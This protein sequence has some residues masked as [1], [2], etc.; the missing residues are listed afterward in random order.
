MICMNAIV[1]IL[2]IYEMPSSQ[3]IDLYFKK[4]PVIIKEE[5]AYRQ[6]RNYPILG[7]FVFIKK[8]ITFRS[9]KGTEPSTSYSQRWYST[10]RSIEH[11][12]NVW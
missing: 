8:P 5:Q 10:T 7:N 6:M 11:E 9:P 12:N 3:A 2:S 1:Y 4:E